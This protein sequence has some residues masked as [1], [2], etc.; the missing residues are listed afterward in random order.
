VTF[1]GRNVTTIEINKE[2]AE[3]AK[4]NF[5]GLENRIKLVVGDA[6][7]EIGKVGDCFYSVALV[8]LFLFCDFLLSILQ[9]AC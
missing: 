5:A 8:C 1:T 7:Q 9:K 2:N 3:C 6:T 4:K